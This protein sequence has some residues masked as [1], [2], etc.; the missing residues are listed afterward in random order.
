MSSRPL[1]RFIGLDRGGFTLVEL[2]IIIVTL[3]ILAAVAIPRFANFG[4]AS[5]VSATRQEMMELKRAIVGNPQVV[6]GSQY[7][8]RGFEGDVGFVPSQLADLS[9]KPDSIAGYNKLTRLG[10]NGPYM[11]S[12]GGNDLTDA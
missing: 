6:S 5:K 1:G 8:E 9:A 3:G 11:D 10:W 2:V 4:E 12:A 7:V